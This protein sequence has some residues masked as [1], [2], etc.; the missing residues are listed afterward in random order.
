MFCWRYI[1][2]GTLRLAYLDDAQGIESIE[3]IPEWQARGQKICHIGFGKEPTVIQ[4]YAETPEKALQ[5]IRKILEMALDKSDKGCPSCDGDA[6][7]DK[8]ITHDGQYL[9]QFRCRKCGLA[10]PYARQI[11]AER[12]WKGHR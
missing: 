10:T 11:P 12:I 9:Y 1:Q 5:K 2:S 8:Q 4:L 6:E 7:I 3:Q